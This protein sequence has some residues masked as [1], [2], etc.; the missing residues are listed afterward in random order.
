[1]RTDK[2][3]IEEAY[4]ILSSNGGDLS[5]VDLAD[6]IAVALEMNE[7]EKKQKLGALYTSL[8]LDGRFVTLKDNTWDLR[9]RH[10][11]EKVHIDVNDVY[12]EIEEAAKENKEDSE[13]NDDVLDLEDGDDNDIEDEEENDEKKMSA[14][15][16]EQLGIK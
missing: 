12:T 1:M 11:Y 6:K 7:E 8:S 10:T 3:M 15:E 16:I 4:E 13:D 2:S 5:F 9:S 14:E